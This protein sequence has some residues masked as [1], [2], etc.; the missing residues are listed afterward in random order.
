MVSAAMRNVEL[1][2]E[3]VRE[4][5]REE[6]VAAARLRERENRLRGEFLPH[7]RQSPDFELMQDEVDDEEAMLEEMTKEYMLG[8]FD[9]DL[10]SK[11]ALPRE[12]DSSGFSGSTWNSSVSSKRTTGGGSLPTVSEVSSQPPQALGQTSPPKLP[13]TS[14]LPPIVDDDPTPT[15]PPTRGSSKQRPPSILSAQTPG[16][17]ARRLS[18]Q[19]KKQLKIETSIGLPPN[20]D[21][22]LTQPP[23]EAPK[24]DMMEDMPPQPKSAFPMNYRDGT[25]ADRPPIPNPPSLPGSSTN[26][27]SLGSG[28]TFT[29]IS[30]ATPA[31]VQVA[32][33][34]STLVPPSPVGAFSLHKN[35]SS[36][37]LK[38][39]NLSMS[40]PDGSDGS[41]ATP[42]SSTFAGFGRK[43][44]NP[45]IAQT[46]LL[47]AFTADTASSGI[48][49][50]END[51]HSPYSPGSPNPLAINAP[52][53]LEP[54]PE[55]FLL[56]PFWLMRC[57]YQ[58]IAHPRGGYLST[59]LFVPRD[60]WR[61]KGVKIK[62]TEEK[63]SNCD[64]LTAALQK[65][66][67]VDSNDADAVFEEMSQFESILDH[68]QSN[69]SKK[70]GNEVGPKD[71][72]SLFK[73]A[74]TVGAGDSH[75]H[76]LPLKSNKE[77]GN[78]YLTSWRKLRSKN[79]AVGLAAAPG[80]S[81]ELSKDALS[82]STLPMTSL[83]N[84]RFAKRDISQVDFEG[85]NAHYMAALARL[86]DA[87]QVIGM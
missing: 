61:V 15:L 65:L 66:A 7:V 51:I 36:L 42:L 2:K 11:S 63:I 71:V 28:D 50:F 31:L 8:D 44:S 1:A 85:P 55:S 46:L 70:L 84:I 87:A 53:P 20:N 45:N 4:I 41:V 14:L 82:M 43:P 73:D 54:C 22:P 26:L 39:R 52:I 17:Q 83:T 6:A 13:S 62:A 32:T 56:R 18:G 79:S 24:I 35:K 34:D 37:S 75:S 69:L 80:A 74:H 9:F 78:K 76:E 30:P 81:K 38:N 3:R 40:S 47:P 59:K 33:S 25:F 23:T 72:T 49:L 12:S 60:V 68:V 5:E 64:L 27:P 16:V 48:H 67:A 21:G 58:T 77:N 57:F 86:F 29:T 19:N 10:S